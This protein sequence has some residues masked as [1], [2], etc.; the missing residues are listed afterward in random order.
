MKGRYMLKNKRYWRVLP[1]CNLIMLLFVY[2]LP[3]G[4]HMIQFEVLMY[5][6]L[7]W[8]LLLYGGFIVVAFVCGLF[9]FRGQENVKTIGKYVLISV[10]GIIMTATVCLFPLVGWRAAFMFAVIMAVEEAI[11]FFAGAIIWHVLSTKFNK[12]LSCKK[13]AEND[14]L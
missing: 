13:G 9:S 10:V 11:G 8:L 1:L 12:H 6:W 4:L 3:V 5:S 7:V 2:A 14:Q